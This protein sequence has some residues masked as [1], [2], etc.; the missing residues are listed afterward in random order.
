MRYRLIIPILAIAMLLGSCSKEQTPDNPINKIDRL[1]FD[2]ENVESKGASTTTN[3]IREFGVFCFDTK[4][5]KWDD[6]LTTATPNKLYNQQVVRTDDVWSYDPPVYWENYQN[7]LHT[8]FAYSPVA[9][10]M[11][12]DSINGNNIKLTGTQATVGVP[13]LEFELIDDISDQIDLLVAREHYNLKPMD[14][15]KM[16]FRHALSRIGFKAFS[17]VAGTYIEKI[18][19]VAIP[20]KGSIPM[21]AEPTW[22]ITADTKNFTLDYGNGVPILATEANAIDISAPGRYLMAIPNQWT[23]NTTAKIRVYYR[24]ASI[25]INKEFVIGITKEIWGQNKSVTY[26]LDLN[27][28]PNK[29]LIVNK[30]II[31]EWKLGK[32]T[33][34]DIGLKGENYWLRFDGN[35]ATADIPA[36]IELESGILYK[37]PN[38][39]PTNAIATFKNWN[40]AQDDS[41]TSYAIGER[42]PINDA[43]VTLYA[44]WN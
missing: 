27:G 29:D 22:N 21:V 37:I 42:V 25:S 13:R 44:Q 19:I 18:E 17:E 30:V 41:G 7:K 23:N 8:F 35:G 2:V 32:I 5:S 11:L 14:V 24:Q 39:T 34:S 3:S 28:D 15:V 16:Q 40:T 1:V 4:Q 43:N 9:K 6:V 36:N 12:P 38:I 31:E 26:L 33:D 10:G 20:Y